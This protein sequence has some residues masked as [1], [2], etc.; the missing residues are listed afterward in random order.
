MATFFVDYIRETH[1]ALDEDGFALYDFIIENIKTPS[2][3]K[4][5]TINLKGLLDEV[6]ADNNKEP[7]V[8]KLKEI[9]LALIEDGQKH[10]RHSVYRPIIV[11]HSCARKGKRTGS[12]RV[13]VY[14]RYLFPRRLRK[15][16]HSED[17]ASQHPQHG[18]IESDPFR[19]DLR[20]LFFSAQ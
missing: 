1:P 5:Q 13:E 9:L 18:V 2:N 17:R 3:P 6:F 8:S 10:D 7:D 16:A 20:N 11:K 15:F 12:N 14:C 4:P 19:P